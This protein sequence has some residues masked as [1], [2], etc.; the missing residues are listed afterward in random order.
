MITKPV[1]IKPQNKSH[2]LILLKGYHLQTI[3]K[4]EVVARVERNTIK[5]RKK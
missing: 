4:I 2:D 5:E 3:A 1:V